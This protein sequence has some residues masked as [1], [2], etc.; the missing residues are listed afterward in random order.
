[1]FFM[2]K[3]M[4]LLLCF[5]HSLYAGM[6]PEGFERFPS[7]Y[8]VET[9]TYGG[10]G[11]RFA[12]RAK[13][14]EIHTIE[15][16]TAL[17]KQA[18]NNFNKL[19]NVHVWCGDSGIMLKDVIKN[20]NKPITFWLD[21][22]WGVPQLNGAKCTPLLEELD[23]IKTHPIK[24]H[25]ILIDDIRC[26]GT[27]LFDFLTKEQIIQKIL[28]INPHYTI[29]YIDGSEDRKNDIMVASVLD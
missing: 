10:D 1:M 25:T 11:V 12:L 14:P 20:M 29:M 27:V 19:H 24:T 6:A 23:Q 17:A 3:L 16:D 8:F 28:E 22:H 9:G 13:F 2:K 21:G 7:Q 15:I 26:C 18:Q 5:F 4:V